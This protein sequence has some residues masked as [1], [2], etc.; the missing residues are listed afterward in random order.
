MSDFNDFIQV[1]LP[2]RPFVTNDGTSGQMLVRSN[3]ID[4]P[5]EMIWVDVSGGSS[6]PNIDVIAADIIH[7][8][9]AISLNEN[10]LAVE[11]SLL[12]SDLCFGVSIQSAISG[13]SFKVATESNTITEN[14]WNWIPGKQIFFNEGGFLTQEIN[15]IVINPIG[16]ALTPTKIQIRIQPHTFL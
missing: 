8:H 3:N 5:R 12:E 14:T 1:E 2:K 6:P 15:N 9:R 11:S 16:I 10:G 7:A 4:R 13:A